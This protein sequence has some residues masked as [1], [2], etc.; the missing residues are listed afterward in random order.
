MVLVIEVYLEDSN[1]WISISELS[2]R[3]L[4]TC[5]KYNSGVVKSTSLEL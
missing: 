5:E 3:Q 4:K 1:T 2:K